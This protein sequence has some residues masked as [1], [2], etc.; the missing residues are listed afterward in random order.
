[1]SRLTS[2]DASRADGGFLRSVLAFSA[3]TGQGVEL[4]RIRP[5]RAPSGLRS[6][7]LDAVRALALACS[8][9]VGGGFDGSP[10]LRFEPGAVGAGEFHLDLTGA[11]A[12]APL[13]QAVATVLATAGGQSTV[14]V[15]GGTHVSGGAP[16]EF[17]DRHWSPLAGRIGL[18][19]RLRLLKAGFTPGGGTLR[20][21]VGA[22]TRPAGLSLESRGPLVELRGVSGAARQKPGAA[23]AARQ[24]EAARRWLWE[25]RRLESRWEVREDVPAASPGAFLLVE[26]VFEHTRGAFELL[27]QR[28][29]SPELL[30]E[31]AARTLLR[32]LDAE[33][34]LDGHAAAQLALPLGLGRGGG[35]LTTSEVT[36]P[37]AA[38]A[39]ALQRFG[40]G[41]RVEGR[42]GG[43]G[44]LEVAAW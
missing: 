36:H 33:G 37:L 25:A 31:R 20:A 28:R 16:F 30:G 35:R 12:V 3:A 44:A 15:A 13:L 39:E 6:E 19:V 17:L 4:L 9:R 41:A 38:A 21:T 43:P 22:W 1:M 5:S 18:P 14:E 42:L 23:V 8:A 29:V 40:I 26:A 24:A 7:H 27:G 11:G 10:D 2:I 34:A 32:F